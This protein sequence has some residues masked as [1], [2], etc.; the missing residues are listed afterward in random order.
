VPIFHLS[1]PVLVG[2]AAVLA[3][4]VTGSVAAVVLRRLQPDK[5][6]DLGP[7]VG[8]WWLICI[9]FGAGLAAGWQAFT[10][11]MALVSLAALAEFIRLAPTHREDR[12]VIWML[13]GS[14]VVSYGTI[15][16]DI[17]PYF[18]VIAPIYIFVAGAALMAVVGR[19][20]GF[21][22]RIGVLQWG[23]IAC[24]YFLGHIA[25]LM[26]TPAAEVPRAGP[27]GLV[28]FLIFTTQLNDIAQ[29]VWGKALGR[30]PIVPRVSPNKTWEGAVGGW[31]TT[32]VVFVW[33]APWFTPL[34]FW[35]S[36]L[37]GGVLP[38]L[39][40][41]GDITM[42]AIKR[43]IGVKDTSGLIPGHGGVLDRVDSLTFTAPWYFHMLAIFAL[44]RF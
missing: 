12:P 35:P 29:Y 3:M 9:V 2:Y 16:A 1:R 40:F 17:Y 6:R 14:V 18:L 33:L 22:A 4:L 26:R 19:T 25:F 30:H 36:V 39:G 32:S 5:W 13:Y 21:M 42:S 10:L 20:D 37:I 7:R 11:L 27:E 31:L 41:F 15:W 23:V 38:V 28:F 34:A 24:V 44:K 8:S 43:D